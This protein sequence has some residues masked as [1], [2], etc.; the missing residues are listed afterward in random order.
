MHQLSRFL[1][2][3]LL[4]AALAATGGCG[5]GGG[6]GGGDG[7]APNQHPWALVSATPTSGAYPLTVTLDGSASIDYDGTI[8]SYQWDFGDGETGSGA[9]VAHQ[10]A[11]PGRYS[12]ALTVTD[13]DGA[14]HSVTQPDLIEV[15]RTVWRFDV[16]KPV[17]CSAPAAGA[18]GTTHFATGV[19]IHTST[20]SLY[21]VNP[22]GTLKWKYGLENSSDDNNIWTSDNNGASPAI[23]A[24]GTICL[25]DH[26]N[27]VYALNPDGT[28]K[29]KE[30]FYNGI[31]WS[32]PAIMPDGTLY[33]G[34]NRSEGDQVWYGR[35][36]AIRTESAGLAAGLWPKFRRD[37]ANSGRAP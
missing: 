1:G 37:L 21:A 2:T 30:N 4:A 22:D 3:T 25:V 5:G 15:H 17:Y 23:A 35:L 32:S 27:V 28:L 29:W 8:I 9:I 6:K 20:G 24:D 26:R 10:Y 19:Q 12:V 11:A 33:I 34:G 31:N 14:T 18:D 16:E 7:E 13:D 36:V